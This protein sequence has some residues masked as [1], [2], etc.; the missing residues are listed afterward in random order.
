M[1]NPLT[2]DTFYRISSLFQREVKCDE[3]LTHSQA[4]E[5]RLLDK[6]L[7]F[8]KLAP[9]LVSAIIRRLKAV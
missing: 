7:I 2:S 8:T 6:K 1:R 5:S 9:G 4:D 3:D